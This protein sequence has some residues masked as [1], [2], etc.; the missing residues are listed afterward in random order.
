MPVSIPPARTIRVALLVCAKFSKIVV[1]NHGDYHSM[2]RR[3]L[4]NTL[5][6][7]SGVTLSLEPY[8]VM[9]GKYPCDDELLKYDALMITGSRTSL[10]RWLEYT[11][12]INLL[13]QLLMRDRTY[14]GSPASSTTCATSKV[15]TLKLNFMVS[16]YPALL[17]NH[18]K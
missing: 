5:P 9:E 12:Q 11:R 14:H 3:W 13:Y 1:A 6:P 10:V 15:T 4:K 8:D 18:L 2:F 17:L 7:R 16:I